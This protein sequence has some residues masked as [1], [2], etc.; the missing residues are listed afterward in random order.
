MTLYPSSPRLNAK[1]HLLWQGCKGCKGSHVVRSRLRRCLPR[2][3]ANEL[4][5]RHSTRLVPSACSSINQGRPPRAFLHDGPP[6]ECAHRERQRKCR[7]LEWPRPRLCGTPGRPTLGG[8]DF[9]ASSSGANKTTT[10][11]A[12]LVLPAILKGIRGVSF[13]SAALSQLPAMDLAQS[14]ASLR[15]ADSAALPELPE[16][17][18]AE[19]LR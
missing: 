11:T 6:A 12:L 15:V 1:A 10:L 4:P 14:L 7:K 17:L 9:S 8:V 19:V 5:S 2:Q 16:D 3:W 18:L 13:V